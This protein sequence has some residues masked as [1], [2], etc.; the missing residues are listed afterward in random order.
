MDGK[1]E[2]DSGVGAY[3]RRFRSRPGCS[4]R[5]F[6]TDLGFLTLPL[7]LGVPFLKDGLDVPCPP[8]SPHLDFVSFQIQ[9]V[10]V[11]TFRLSALGIE[12]LRPPALEEEEVWN[13]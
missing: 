9:V 12:V 3:G 13:R 1:G 6:C 7:V 10:S 11:P 4:N 2:G 8:S 5:F